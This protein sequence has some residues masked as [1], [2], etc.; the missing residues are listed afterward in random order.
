[1]YREQFLR[2]IF[3]SIGLVMSA[4]FWN[5][6]VARAQTPE[7]PLP[8]MNA[9]FRYV[10]Q[11]FEQS[12]SDDPRYARIE[13]LLD[14]DGCD[15]ILLDKTTNREALYSISKRRVDALAANGS[16][17]YI[18]PIA[19]TDSRAENSS[20]V[21]LI[22]FRDLFGNEVSWKF[23]A[24]QI[25]PHA[26]PKVISR[27]DNA[28]IIF[29]YAPRRAPSADGTVLTIAGREYRPNSRPSDNALAAFY[30]TE[31]TLG[32]ILPGTDLWTVEHSPADVVQTAKW[33]LAGGG[34]LRTLVVKE[35]SA[36]EAL[37]EQFDVNDPDAPHVIL[38]VVRVN[39]AYELRSLSFES[40]FN[41]LWIFF[42]PLLPLPAHGVH[43][44]RTVTFTIAENEQANI[45]SGELEVRRAVDA[46]HVLWHFETPS[47]A[48]GITL[49]TG[50]NLIPGSWRRSGNVRS[51]FRLARGDV[52]HGPP[53][54]VRT[55]RRHE[56]PHGSG[57]IP[58]ALLR[59]ACLGLPPNN[60][61][62]MA[63]S[64]V[65]RSLHLS[66]GVDDAHGIRQDS[67]CWEDTFTT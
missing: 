34:R 51:D 18:T 13:A 27:T 65:I 22:H 3:V 32:Q 43:D 48:R 38:N 63:G 49:E 1:V 44:K 6:Y 30:A 2:S 53:V 64:I 39:E 36:T 28:S 67:L 50:V 35:R 29:L 15:V 9:E 25:L 16:D 19:L 61:F 47:F 57:R 17:A 8:P 14:E 62:A 4:F 31:V 37:I 10:P 59:S 55:S 26:L 20:S 40:H 56:C 54:Y 42:G 66:P 46:E 41:T 33:N 52:V 21:F 12:I 45:A 5:A 11:Y 24:G 23:V 7:P 60:G 58:V